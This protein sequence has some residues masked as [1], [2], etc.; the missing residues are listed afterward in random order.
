MAYLP[1]TPELFSV[2][3]EVCGNFVEIVLCAKKLDRVH[4]CEDMDAL[5]V[6]Q[7]ALPWADPN[8]MRQAPHGPVALHYVL[9]Y[10]ICAI[11]DFF[12]RVYFV[13]YSPLQRRLGANFRLHV[14]HVS[15]ALYTGAVAEAEIHPVACDYVV[16]EMRV[17]EIEL[18]DAQRDIGHER[19]LIM[20]AY[21]I[22]GGDGRDLYVIYEVRH[23]IHRIGDI[24]IK[25]YVGV[26]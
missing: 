5:I 13:D 23:E 12:A 21:A 11:Q 20:L 25:L 24:D 19:E 22:Y 7:G 3:D 14:H 6:L 26:L 2:A 15:P 16:G 10:L 4:L 17:G 8:L 1:V 18:R 9:S